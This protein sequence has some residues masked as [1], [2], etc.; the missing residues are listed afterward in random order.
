MAAGPVVI[1]RTTFGITGPSSTRAIRCRSNRKESASVDSKFQVI[2]TMQIG[3]GCSVTFTPETR[4]LG[5]HIAGGEDA[6][7]FNFVGCIQEAAGMTNEEAQLK[8]RRAAYAALIQVLEESKQ[9]AQ[10]VFDELQHMA[11]E[12]ASSPFPQN[13]GASA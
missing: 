2:A 4:Q 1:V 8:M 10:K 7:R 12:P 9:E 3:F 6:Q 11:P 5:I 13:G